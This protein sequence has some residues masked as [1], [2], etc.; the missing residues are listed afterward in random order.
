MRFKINLSELTDSL[1]KGM[2]RFPLA[3]LCAFTAMVYGNLLIDLRGEE[4]ESRI[5]L[6]ISLGLGISLFTGLGLS[7]FR[8][9]PLQSLLIQL[10]GLPILVLCYYLLDGVPEEI[11]VGR[12]FILGLLFH[13]YVS[14]AVS[15]KN[16]SQELFWQANQALLLRLLNTA[17]YSIVLYGG[18]ALAMSAID[19][20]FGVDFN[21]SYARLYIFI[22]FV[23]NTWFFLSGLKEEEEVHFPKGL[24]VFTQF[25]LI[26]LVLIYFLILYAYAGKIVIEWSWPIGWVSNLILGFSI[27]G[28]LA[29]LLV[30]PISDNA[31]NR[32]M[33]LTGRGIFIA[34]VPLVIMMALAVLR[35]I[36]DYGIT[37]E[38]YYI[39]NLTAWLAFI[40]IFYGF[41][42]SRNIKLIPLSLALIALINVVGPLSG[43]SVSKRNQMARLVLALEENGLMEKDQWKAMPE[44]KLSEE[45]YKRI[46]GPLIYL[47]NRQHY[48]LLNS[49]LP[50]GV[51]TDEMM[52]KH[53]SYSNARQILGKM[54]S[55]EHQFNETQWQS[56]SFRRKGKGIQPPQGNYAAFFHINGNFYN[57]KN[58]LEYAG[59]T[60]EFQHK[61]QNLMVKVNEEQLEINLV[62]QVL[63]SMNL[64]RSQ[65]K[66]FDNEFSE[67][68][69]WINLKNEHYE[70][71]IL[72]EDFNFNTEDGEL[73]IT[74][75]EYY[76]WVKKLN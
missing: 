24:R 4:V 41:L 55:D 72:L 43:V 7:A 61:G 3:F 45:E 26:P 32:L 68:Q 40:S 52:E 35:R 13:L 58:K 49:I 30:F 5:P 36:N 8:K 39:S 67:S 27:T 46:E 14:L 65:L 29:Y 71:P 15:R 12:T 63:K 21:R 23:F 10:I 54:L 53:G 22:L 48:T 2:L 16:Q 44:K 31:D 60:F 38:R 19:L 69:A 17:F 73:V 18:L 62:D 6:M 64:E 56:F 42:R 59:M 51:K 28:I 37:E 20:L 75:L 1:L 11:Q 70:I 57:D 50:E 76:V 74:N 25:V 9:P 47:L 33:R 66:A 34:L